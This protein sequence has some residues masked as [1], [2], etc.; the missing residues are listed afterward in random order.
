MMNRKGA[1]F[2]P[3]QT[4]EGGGGRKLAYFFED[5]AVPG[6]GAN[7]MLIRP[8]LRMSSTK[9]LFS[10]SLGHSFISLH[11][12]NGNLHGFFSALIF[13]HSRADIAPTQD[14]EK[15]RSRLLQISSENI[16]HSRY[17]FFFFFS[18]F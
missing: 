18:F 14:A 9:T 5:I 16:S 6:N 10:Y 13:M 12:Y 7:H 3:S 1:I 8:L 4:R 17:V 11:M 15:Y 2:Q